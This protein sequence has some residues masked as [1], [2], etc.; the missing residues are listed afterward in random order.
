V[1]EHQGEAELQ[2]FIAAQEPAGEGLG[3]VI[4]DANSNEFLGD[5]LAAAVR[6]GRAPVSGRL[7]ACSCARRRGAT[8]SAVRLLSRSALTEPGLARCLHIDTHNPASQCV[9]VRCRFTREGVLPSFEERKAHRSDIV[10]FSL[11]PADLR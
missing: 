6:M 4:V 7:P 11:L 8:A 1:P 2:R 3:P 5:H 10:V 9:A